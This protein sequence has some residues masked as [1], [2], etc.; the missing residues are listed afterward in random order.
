MNASAALRHSTRTLATKHAFAARRIAGRRTFQRFQS[1]STS[2]SSGASSSYDASHLAAGVAGGTVVLLGGYMYYYFSGAKSAVDA[3]RAASQY[4]QETK[5]AIASKAPNSPNEAL[6]YLRDVARSYLVIIPGARPHVDAA[7]DTIDELRST[8]GDD[9]NRIVSDGYEE[10]SVVIKDSGSMDAAVAMKILDVLRRRSAELEE[11][12]KKAGKDAFGSLSEKYPQLSEKL[13]GGYEEFKRL[14]ESKG[15]EAKKV[16]D[17]T[18]RQLKDIFSKGFSQ[19]SFDDARRLI[20]SKTSD[21]RRFAQQSSQEAW[22]R[23][24][25]EA[26]PY[27]DKAPEIKQLLNDN[28]DK[29]IAAGAATIS[30][31]SSGMQEVF[32]HIKD[33][34]QGDMAKNKDKMNE[35]RKFVEDKARE[36]EAQGTKQLER[37]WESLQDWIRTMPGGEDALK[38]MPDVQV[39]VKVSQERSE[40]AKK[41]AKETYEAVLQV[42]EEK[43]KK[44]KQLSEEVK[45]DTK[46]S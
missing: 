44:A 33:V 29:F 18:S 2:S 36:A 42:L 20:Q 37:G 28:R 24:L 26:T 14:A 41:L 10:V 23:A 31:G 35:L 1:T 45:E 46:S 11:L 5:A 13:G 30:G 38:R 15:P 39:F 9:V 8:H 3:S 7:F 4:Y 25:K 17:E 27:L 22:D 34:A 40:D 43:G 19:N 21:L 6:D 12:G 32:S 16:Y